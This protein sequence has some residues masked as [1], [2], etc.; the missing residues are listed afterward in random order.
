MHSNDPSFGTVLLYIF[1]IV[2]GI[3]A[4]ITSFVITKQKSFKKHW[5]KTT[6]NDLPLKWSFNLFEARNPYL[7]GNYS[8]Q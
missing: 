5:R 3:I 7:I 4:V 8:I 2:Y 1:L 6:K